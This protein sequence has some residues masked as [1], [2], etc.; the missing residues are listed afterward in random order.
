MMVRSHLC[1]G[2]V[3]SR[4]FLHL[5]HME[6]SGPKKAFLIVKSLQRRRARLNHTTAVHL[7]YSLGESLKV[8]L[9]KKTTLA[10]IIIRLHPGKRQR[11]TWTIEL[12]VRKRADLD[13]MIYPSHLRTQR[14]G[15]GAL[16]K[17]TEEALGQESR[18][19]PVK[20]SS[21]SSHSSFSL[22]FH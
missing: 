15:S 17:L 5:H 21:G 9:N 22:S 8:N 4:P 10:K 7:T 14:H 2:H 18:E 11:C 20:E 1:V 6:K 3:C 13:K 19:K 16:A 12:S